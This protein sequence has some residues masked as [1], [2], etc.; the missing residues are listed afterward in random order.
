MFGKI[1]KVCLSVLAACSLFTLAACRDDEY[2]YTNDVF[3]VWR[4]EQLELGGNETT[5]SI[6]RHS[7]KLYL[8]GKTYSVSYG[9]NAGDLYI[10]DTEKYLALPFGSFDGAVRIWNASTE[11]KGD[12]LYLTVTRDF[13]FERGE[14]QVD[15]TGVKY[16]LKK[17]WLKSS[18]FEEDTSGE[19]TSTKTSVDSSVERSADN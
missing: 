1:L 9:Y 12:T 16:V 5:E 11:V 17:S 10:F 7:G 3:C 6:K 13:L 15:H 4:C 2:F 18:S 19:D 8:D 14:S